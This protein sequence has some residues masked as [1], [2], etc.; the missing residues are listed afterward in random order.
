MGV[1]YASGLLC[2]DATTI[3]DIGDAGEHLFECCCKYIS[4]RRGN[5]YPTGIPLLQAVIR[6]LLDGV[7]TTDSRI[8]LGDKKFQR[9]AGTILYFLVGGSK[10]PYS[11]AF[12]ERL[13]KLG[14]SIGRDFPSSFRNHVLGEGIDVENFFEQKTAKEAIQEYDLVLYA[15]QQLVSIMSRSLFQTTNGYLGTGPKGMRCGD[16]IC[17]LFGSEFPIILRQIGSCYVHIG[18]CFLQGF[19]D[20]EAVKDYE[21]GMQQIQKFEIH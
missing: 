3:Y 7:D 14:L 18:P 1:L 16:Q 17:F 13:P 8:A 21:R 10:S 9:L 6:V 11:V 15:G 12:E 20:G 2:E 5:H 4:D 19:M